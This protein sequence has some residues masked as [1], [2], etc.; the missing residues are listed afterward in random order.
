M[1]LDQA[2]ARCRFPRL[3]AGL[4]CDHDDDALNRKLTPAGNPVLP[5]KRR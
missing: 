5:L 3:P 1:R 2:P 4:R